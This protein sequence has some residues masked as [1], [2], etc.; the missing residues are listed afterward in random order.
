M[1][2]RATVCIP[3]VLV[4]VATT[5]LSPA[6][7]RAQGA[8]GIA[9]ASE[10]ASTQALNLLNSGQF[11]QAEAAY[12]QLLQQ[13][14]TA[15]V[16]PE[17]LFRL[18]YAQYMQAEYSQA[19]AS[20]KKITSP[21]AAPEI[22]AAGDALIPQVMAAQ[23]A[24]MTS[25]DP[26]RKRSLGDAIV[27]FQDFIDKHPR[28]Q[29]AENAAYGMATSEFQLG[30]YES[31]EKTLAG[32]LQNYPNNDSFL[33]NE[34]LLGVVLTADA[35][36][37][38]NSHG[39]SEDA[40]AKFADAL[41]RLADVIQRHTDVALA[42]NAQ[43]QIGEVLFD[44]A[45]AETGDDQKKDLTHAIDAYQAVQP[46][47]VMI[48]AQQSRV[49]ESLQ[50]VQQQT[51]AHNADAAAQAQQRQDRETAKLANVKLAPDETLNAQLRMAA[52]YFLLGKFD[53]SRT[54]LNYLRPFATDPDP[55]Q[56]LMYY[57]VLT[58]ASQGLM[59]KAEEAYSNFQAQYKGAAIGENLPIVMG[60]AFLSGTPSQPAKAVQYFQ[61]EREIYPNSP[62]VNQSL[63]QQA[64][65]LVRQQKFDEAISTYQQFLGTNP[66]KDQAADAEQG[67]A[68]IYQ[69]TG[70]L[71]DAMKQ[72]QEVADKY[73]GTA[74]AEQCAFYAAALQ[75]AVDIKQALPKLQ[76]F[77]AK[78]PNGK[79]TAQATLAIGQ[80]QAS[81]GDGDGA[82]K[83]YKDLVAKFPKSDSAP[84][85]YFQEAA[86]LARDGKSA[87][88]VALMKD[89]IKAYPEDKN[90]YY[91]YDTIGASQV[92]S[93]DI[94][95]A[96]ATYAEMAQEHSD[97]PMAAGA[98]EKT[99]E[100][101]RHQADAQGRY[102]SLD[103]DQKKQWNDGVNKSVEAAEGV[104]EKFPDS[105]QVGLALKTLLADQRMLLEAQVKTPEDV[106]SYFVKLAVNYAANP[107]IQNRVK[108]TLGAFTYESD[109]QAGLV[110][111]AAA[112][113]PNLIYAPDDLDMYGEA[114]IAQSRAGTAF[115]VY[116]KLAA[117]YPVPVGTEAARAPTA[118]Q[119]AQAMALF[120]MATALDNEGKTDEAGKYF[121]QLKATYP[122]SPKVMEANYGIAK[123]LVADKKLDDALKL[124]EGIV[125]SR[126]ATAPLH[127]HALLLI[128]DIFSAKGNIPAAIDSY[129]KTAAFYAAVPDAASEGLWHG[130]QLLEQQAKSLTETSTPK[131][132]EQI[133]KAV[134]AY[135]KIVTNYS[136]S[137]YV[138]QAQ[139]RLTTLGVAPGK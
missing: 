109:P 119:D 16:A 9:Q 94:A 136:A 76:A 117:D 32:N 97:N 96:V 64:A 92:N 35:N 21:P 72:Y 59:D 31:A 27:A 30:D 47:D 104:L 128:G 106:H 71:A 75:T 52:A 68:A 19:L 123:S 58:Y 110:A 38:E 91:A 36:N 54:V 124:L 5:A 138:Q 108:F 90:I 33:D 87:D 40:E 135:K 103:D 120:G 137:Q 13:Y 42:N 8:A 114:L 88:L 56:Q 48:Q 113:K 116:Q 66:P 22:K 130:A 69:Q 98:Q 60:A 46:Q 65:A 6:S 80:V 122:W 14:P 39:S 118:I 7:S 67:I 85:A 81:Q 74:M 99:A 78:F 133:A 82:M 20:L 105:D 11:Q 17:A 57:T 50:A 28:T 23:G 37:I 139:D 4:A 61:Q 111:M 79:F 83:T 62:L 24:A 49:A 126:T 107:G 51:L 115:T 125:P 77:V 18:G 53:E 132:S 1:I 129:L 127:A 121:A 100:L 45:N 10:L 102:Q 25:T 44:R 26:N 41:K 84:Q 43:F 63:D 34:D 12:T 70:K 55:K 95:G 2:R 73:P 131:K 29:A 93:G 134:A 89:F 101:W 86:I 15:A 112:Y 3:L